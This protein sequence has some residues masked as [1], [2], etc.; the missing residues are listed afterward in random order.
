MRRPAWLR[1]PWVSAEWADTLQERVDRLRNERDEAL[2]QRDTAVFN[3]QQIGG[4]LAE[5]DA[6]NR[7]VHDRN[8]ELGRR[9]SQLTE[10]DPE[11]TAQLERQVAELQQRL[12]EAAQDGEWRGRARRAEKRIAHLEKELDDACGMPPGGLLDSAP[13]QPGYKAERDKQVAP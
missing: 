6:T 3:R 9:I 1:W 2:G 5:A 4:Q 8:L 10:S 11:Y 12:A 13:W 7:R